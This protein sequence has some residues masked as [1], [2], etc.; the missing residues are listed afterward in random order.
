MMTLTTRIALA[1]A[2]FGFAS[3]LGV[4]PAQAAPTRGGKDR[5]H[6]KGERMCAK[7][8]CSDAQKARIKEIKTAGQTPQSKAARDNLRTLREQVRAELRKPSPDPKTVAR[9]DAQIATQKAALH[10]QHRARQ[11]QILAV[12]S[13]EQKA[14]FLDHAGKRGKGKGKGKANKARGAQRG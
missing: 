9:L 3:L 4:S 8:A 11:L 1:L 10:S 5:T 7:L 12:L 6:A 2:S 13:P 14:R